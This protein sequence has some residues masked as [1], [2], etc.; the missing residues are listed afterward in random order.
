MVIIEQIDTTSR[1]E[2][3]EFIR[4]PFRLY[5]GVPQ[6]VPPFI[7]DV[8]TMLDKHK[9]PFYEHSEADFFIAKRG[10]EVVGRIAALHNR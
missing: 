1:A 2:V 6:W 8:R 5:K 9:H 4:F 7:S 3:D 10:K